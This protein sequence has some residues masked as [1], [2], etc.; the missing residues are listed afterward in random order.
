MGKGPGW[1]RPGQG[2]M[3]LTGVKGFSSRI[4]GHIYDLF[5][6]GNE[7]SWICLSLRNIFS[8]KVLIMARC[9]N[10][11]S[12]TKLFVP[13]SLYLG[14]S[15]PEF[16]LTKSFPVN[17]VFKP[18]LMAFLSS[19]WCISCNICTEHFNIDIK[20]CKCQIKP[21][22]LYQIRCK[23]QSG[24]CLL[25]F[26]NVYVG[27]WLTLVQLSFLAPSPTL[28]HFLGTRWGG[29][30]AGTR[31]ASKN[32]GWDQELFLHLHLGARRSPQMCQFEGSPDRS[33]ADHWACFTGILSNT[34]ISTILI[35]AA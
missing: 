14:Q 33:K 34:S 10:W 26:C 12:K 28:H 17:I 7:T 30:E 31:K 5:W 13:K 11:F 18:S 23:T 2:L 21:D 29:R 25:L 22:I 15:L 35:Y 16:L 4:L 8:G 24:Y 6:N 27:I 20:D 32:G 3:G 1:P 9:Q 19:K